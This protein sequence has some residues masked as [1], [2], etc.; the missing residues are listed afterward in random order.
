MDSNFSKKIGTIAMV[1]MIAVCF[2]PAAAG[3]ASPGYGRHDSGFDGKGRHRSALGIW[4]SPQTVQQLELTK[5][6]VKQLR[7]ADFAFREKHL[8]LKAQM[9]RFRLQM[10][11]AFSDD[12]VDNGAVRQLAKQMSDLQGKMFVQKIE[13]RLSL[14]K[15]L[16]TDQIQKLR[17]LDMRMKRR[18]PGPVGKPG[19]GTYPMERPDNG[20][21]FDS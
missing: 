10:N 7:D 16:T 4:R 11:R 6:Q 15:I 2:M 13:S 9:D 21:S 20:P 19:P 5:E 18:G 12:V 3:A 1:F 14:R 8:S 17:P